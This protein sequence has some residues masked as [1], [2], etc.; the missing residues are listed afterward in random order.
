MLWVE[1]VMQKLVAA[2]LKINR[3]KCEFF[4]SKVLYLGY[5]LDPEG[6][7]LDSERIAPI[8]NYP[9][10]ITVK[11]LRRFLGTVGCFARFL[12]HESESKVLLK[13]LL[14]KVQVWEWAPD[15]REF[16]WGFK[17]NT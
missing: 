11:Q 8:V 16:K 12:S 5:L 2:G 6:L 4:C 9:A 15:Q 1:Y 3:E 14:R 10:P 17:G 7:R 13:K